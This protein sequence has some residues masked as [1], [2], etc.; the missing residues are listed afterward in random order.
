MSSR[1][2]AKSNWVNLK[3]IY[4]A[5]YLLSF[6][7]VLLIWKNAELLKTHDS[8]FAKLFIINFT[9]AIPEI[10]IWFVALRS[11]V[12]FKNYASNI[13][14]SKDGQSMN[15]LADALLMIV[16][17]VILVTTSGQITGLFKNSS[18]L[19]TIVQIESY[20]PI[21]IAL[22]ASVLFFMGSKALNRMV[23]LRIKTRTLLAISCLFVIVVGLF[24]WHFYV[25]EPRLAPQDGVPR[26]LL[27]VRTLMFAYIL[28]FIII[29]GLGVYACICFANYSV[30]V[31]GRIYKELFKNLYRGILLVFICIFLAQ[32]FTVSD[33]NLNKF[34]LDLVLVYCLLILASIG[35]VLIYHGSENLNKLEKI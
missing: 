10:V 2:P 26:F 25:I 8:S 16:F 9:I 1:E 22:A 5:L 17:Y 31:K 35:F 4:T 30:M 3:L 20:F 29:W 23:P 15:Y 18:S 34:S 7:Y 27:P 12:H 19:H 32:L 33:T 6:V 11:A 24:A 14:L 21:G 13:R 28:P